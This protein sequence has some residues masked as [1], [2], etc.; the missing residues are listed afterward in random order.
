M[1]RQLVGERMD[2]QTGNEQNDTVLALCLLMPYCSFPN[3]PYLKVPTVLDE[4]IS[5]SIHG[6]GNGI[7]EG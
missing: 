6:W 4:A 1:E 5:V 3:L 2:E 7:R